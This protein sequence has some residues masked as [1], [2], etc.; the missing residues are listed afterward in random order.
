MSGSEHETWVMVVPVI[1]TAHL[2]EEV[3]EALAGALSGSDFFGFM[4]M[5]GPIGG[6]VYLG[7]L[8]LY[9]DDP[10]LPVC[11]RDCGAWANS[12]GHEWVRFDPDGDVVRGL[13]VYEW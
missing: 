1:S 2:S 5:V 6:M 11:L 12:K 8:D 7:D 9:A 13:P 4:C 10:E 3:G